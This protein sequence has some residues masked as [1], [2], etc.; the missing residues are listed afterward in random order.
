FGETI[1][2][3]TEPGDELR[4]PKLKIIAM[5]QVIHTLNAR[6]LGELCQLIVKLQQAGRPFRQLSYPTSGSELALA[7]AE[8][9]HKL[10]E[11]VELEDFRADWPTPFE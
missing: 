3:I 2:N 11:L 4:W 1:D 8:D 7:G 9:I 6:R 10:R 5:S